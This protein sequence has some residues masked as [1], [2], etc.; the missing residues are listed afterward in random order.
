M[1]YQLEFTTSALRELRSLDPQIQRRIAARTT[2]LC[3]DP[4]PPGIK[5]LQGP[6]DHFRLRVGDYRVIYRVDGRRVVVVI[7]RIEH[8]REVYR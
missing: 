3:D 8:R 5:K 7:V 1:R 4:F 6:P 2:A